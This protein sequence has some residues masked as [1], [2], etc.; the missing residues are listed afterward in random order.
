MATYKI[1]RFYQDGRRARVQKTGLTLEQAQAWC[2]DP[3]T[4]SRSARKPAGC[5]NDLKQIQRWDAKQKHW[6]DGYTVEA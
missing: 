3:Q 1:L 4:S 6:F 5:Q 2:N